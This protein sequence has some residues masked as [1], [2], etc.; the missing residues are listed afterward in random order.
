MTSYERTGWRDEAISRRHRAWGFNCPCVDLDFL[1]IEYN[2][3]LPVAV[4]EYKHHQAIEPDLGHPTYG[5][6][7]ELCCIANI[8]FIVARYWKD[9]WAFRIT[10][11]NS[12]ARRVYPANVEL[13]ERRFVAS[14]YYIRGLALERNV[15]EGLDDQL[16]PDQDIENAA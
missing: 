8:P 1:V 6:I 10:P 3:A 12:A 7:N 4:V 11:V 2:R 16:H 15:L 13:T 14:L 5:A 9:P